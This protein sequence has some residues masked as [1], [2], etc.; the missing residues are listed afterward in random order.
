MKEN[1][2]KVIS[3]LR[4]NARKKVTEIAKETGIARSTVFDMLRACES[5]IIIKHTSIVDF[6][7]LG[8]G[9]RAHIALKVEEV[10][11]MKKHLMEHSNVNSVYRVNNGY[12]FVIDCVFRNLKEFY[13]F[14]EELRRAGT[15]EQQVFT[16]VDELK[17]EEFLC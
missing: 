1:R 6:P 4:R 5:S 8:Y 9:V 10:E 3:S 17:R 2:E 16:V 15:R 13:M 7:A 12:D 14:R 11:K